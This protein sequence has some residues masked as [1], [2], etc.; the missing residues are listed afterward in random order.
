MFLSEHLSN[1]LSAIMSHQ[2]TRE[3]P[4]LLFKKQWRLKDEDYR[5]LGQC[6]ALIKSVNN[7]PID[8]KYHQEI[9]G[10]SLIKGAQSTTAI[11][12]NTLTEEEIIK[13]QN[14]EKLQPSKQYQAQEVE[15]IL[16]AFNE[17]VSRVINGE[18]EQ[19]ITP[20][21]LLQFHKMVGSNLGEH[22]QAIPGR[23]REGSN[24]VTVGSYRAADARDVNHL[25]ES[26][27]S[28][29]R[30][31]FRFESGNHTYIDV[32]IEAIVAHVYVEWI[33]PFGDGNGRTGRLVEFY[34]LLRG[35]L[36]DIAL[37]ILSN[38]YNMTRPEYYRQLQKSSETRDLTEF[39][40]YAIIG[41]RD[42]LES[43]LEKIQKSQTSITW[44]AYIY[45][46]F[47]ETPATK[48]DVHKRRR[49]LALELPLY[50]RVTSSQIPDLSVKLAKQYANVS[51]KTLHRDLD[52]LVDMSLVIKDGDTY[53][54][55]IA[56]L[57]TMFAKKKPI[58]MVK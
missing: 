40:R 3:Y 15:N 44:R 36:P 55:N 4:H 34:I 18:K 13:V 7:T 16:N 47:D 42:G 49:C 39:I 52:E 37:H 8:P 31:E 41:L 51:S 30:D 20:E 29:L 56:L 9:K 48:E 43:V 28:F 1:N 46:R 22:F 5:V 54:A 14:G 12:G 21:L 57:N 23:F 35:G 2:L 53:E 45:D 25:I 24:N 32:I 50:E 33:H 58:L 11:E 26:F 17:L 6:D 38:H 19:L 10:V 27:C